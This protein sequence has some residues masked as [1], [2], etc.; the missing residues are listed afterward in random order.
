MSAGIHI[1]RKSI[2]I[3]KYMLM[4]SEI[5][6]SRRIQLSLL[7]ITKQSSEHQEGYFNLTYNCNSLI[8]PKCKFLIYGY[9]VNSHETGFVTG[10]KWI[11]L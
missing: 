7:K 4:S 3:L 2:S 5:D 1:R 8:L 11:Y 6:L 10:K 9:E